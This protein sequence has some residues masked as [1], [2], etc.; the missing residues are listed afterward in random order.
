MRTRAACAR[1]NRFTTGWR[2][3]LAEGFPLL[4]ATRTGAFAVQLGVGLAAAV[5][6]PKGVGGAVG[7]V[8]PGGGVTGSVGTGSGGAVG[9]VGPGGGVTGSV[10]TGSGGNGS[11]SVGRVGVGGIGRSTA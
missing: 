4:P 10:G 7:P 5:V 8:G 1:R 6:E 9:P 2:G 3:R 11:G